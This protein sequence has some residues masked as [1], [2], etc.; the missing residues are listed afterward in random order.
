MTDWQFPDA[1]R[2]TCLTALR[3][4]DRGDISPLLNFARS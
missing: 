2:R 1:L 3:T 4:A